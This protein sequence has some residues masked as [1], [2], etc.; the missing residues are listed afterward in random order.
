MLS[1]LF[2]NMSLER[3]LHDLEN[4]VQCIDCQH[5]RR[6][7]HSTI[8]T[9]LAKSVKF[10]PIDI[11]W[12]IKSEFDGC[13]TAL[14]R[15]TAVITFFNTHKKIFHHE[16]EQMCITLVRDIYH[17]LKEGVREHG[18]LKPPFKTGTHLTGVDVLKAANIINQSWQVTITSNRDTLD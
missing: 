11:N 18:C 5:R 10:L 6:N 15:L 12:G 9:K 4:M 14:L 2:N 7:M 3:K 17:L 13:I 16:D 8:Y 1:A